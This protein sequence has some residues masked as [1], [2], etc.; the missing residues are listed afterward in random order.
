MV[1]EFDARLNASS[2]RIHDAESIDAELT[3]LAYS[4]ERLARTRRRTRLRRIGIP[5]IIGTMALGGTGAALTSPAVQ[6]SLGITHAQPKSVKPF[7]RVIL[8]LPI[9]GCT[10][11]L[12]LTNGSSEPLSARGIESLQAATSYLSHVDVAAI[13]QSATF[14]ANYRPASVEPQ[15]GETPDEIATET[16][17][18][19]QLNRASEEQAVTQALWP[20][21]IDAADRTGQDAGALGS[22][23]WSTC[24]G[25]TS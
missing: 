14:K 9:S 10:L 3:T 21:M 13:E 4:T 17:M 7:P 6:Q 16:Q 2:P 22:S 24:P 8:A 18:I 15:P 20:G 1:D 23:G 25:S 5:L 19:Q 12:Q 11:T